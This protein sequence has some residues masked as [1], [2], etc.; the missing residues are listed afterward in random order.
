M[1]TTLIILLLCLF[2]QCD[3][4]TDKIGA[5]GKEQWFKDLQQPCKKDDTCKTTIHKA[6]YD[7]K[8]VYFTSLDGGLCDVSFYVKLY[9]EHGVVVKEY[10]EQNWADY[11]KEVTEEEPI[12]R[13]TGK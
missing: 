1:K 3:D 9:N 11:G 5:V 6:V 2:I 10:D 7:G 12:W 13:C 8:T 4:D